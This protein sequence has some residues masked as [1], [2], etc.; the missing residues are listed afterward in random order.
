MVPGNLQIALDL[1]EVVLSL[2]RLEIL[3]RIAL[4]QTA[5]TWL[6]RLDHL[7]G[8]IPVVERDVVSRVVL[9]L[10]VELLR[11]L[12]RIAAAAGPATRRRVGGSALVAAGAIAEEIHRHRALRRLGSKIDRLAGR[13]STPEAHTRPRRDTEGD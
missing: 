5:D 8:T 12:A 7:G 9:Q 11:R 4:V 3:P 10:A 2:G 1:G 6:H 13:A